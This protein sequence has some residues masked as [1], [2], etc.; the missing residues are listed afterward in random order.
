M[1]INNHLLH[2]NLSTLSEGL[3]VLNLLNEGQYIST[4][5]PVIE[6]TIGAHFRHVIEHYQC[7]IE[8]FE[9]LHILFVCLLTLYRPIYSA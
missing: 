1:H 5:K 2:S 6:S 8:H 4:F 3:D 7:F 9:R